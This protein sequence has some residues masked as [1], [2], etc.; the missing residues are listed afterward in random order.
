MLFVC[1]WCVVVGV[2][3]FWCWFVVG[4][5]TG[6]ILGLN[7]LKVFLNETRLFLGC[8][9]DAVTSFTSDG[10]VFGSSGSFNNGTDNY[11]K[12]C[13]KA[14]TTSGINQDSATITPTAYSF[15]QTAGFSIIASAPS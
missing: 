7:C 13:W 14:G 1:C 4:Q 11:V 12:W 8:T 10:Y 6:N 3:S 9:R 15:N 2:L 5:W